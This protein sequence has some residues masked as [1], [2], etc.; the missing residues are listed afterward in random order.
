MGSDD[1]VEK[2]FNKVFT[3]DVNRLRGMEDM[4]KSRA[5]PEPLSYETLREQAK[6]VESTIPCDDQKVWTLVEDFAVFQD[7]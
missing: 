1:F 7:R 2:I 4:W 5:P 6:A 3:D